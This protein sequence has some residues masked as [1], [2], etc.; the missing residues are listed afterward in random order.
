MWRHH[1]K[2][3]GDSLYSWTIDFAARRAKAREETQPL[4][5]E[6]A[7]IKAAVVDLKEQIRHLKK[8][9]AK[10]VEW[11]ALNDQILKKDKA[12][13]D[14]ES[15]ADDIDAAVYDLKAV[16]PTAMVATH[17]RKQEQIIDHKGV[18]GRN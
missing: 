17:T 11:L 3:K 4:L 2:P 16:T 9:K 15:K 8:T 7:K 1:G 14:L 18:Q 5:D 12:T 13:R 6:A 10:E